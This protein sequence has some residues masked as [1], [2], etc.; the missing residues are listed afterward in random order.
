MSEDRVTQALRYL[1]GEF[2]VDRQEWRNHWEGGDGLLD[3]LVGH[4]YA[5]EQNGRFGITRD[6]RARLDDVVVCH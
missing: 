3:A 6:G 5:Q 2:S 1:A 4:R